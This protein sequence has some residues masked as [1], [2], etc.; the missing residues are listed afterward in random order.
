MYDNIRWNACCWNANMNLFQGRRHQQLWGVSAVQ[1]VH[2]CF[3]SV[4]HTEKTQMHTKAS[5]FAGTHSQKTTNQ[6]N[7]VTLEVKKMLNQN[8]FIQHLWNCINRTKSIHNLSASDIKYLFNYTNFPYTLS[9]F[10]EWDK[11]TLLKIFL[12]KIHCKNPKWG[13]F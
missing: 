5:S 4:H 3:Q 7:F 8:P 11:Q 12:N 10:S 2:S 1:S 6:E 13:Y 9:W